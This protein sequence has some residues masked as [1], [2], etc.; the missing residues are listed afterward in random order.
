M[1]ARACDGG[2]RGKEEGEER[3]GGVLCTGKREKQRR[4]M[5]K[6]LPCRMERRVEGKS[7]GGRVKDRRE[8]NEI[9]HAPRLNLHLHF[10]FVLIYSQHTSKIITAEGDTRVGGTRKKVA[11]FLVSLS[12]PAS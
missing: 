8:A 12:L 11:W 10:S 6:G 4:R 1:T 9:T 2:E 3:R 7:T 5:R